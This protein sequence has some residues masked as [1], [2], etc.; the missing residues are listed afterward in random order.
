MPDWTIEDQLAFMAGQGISR[1]IFSFST[2]GPNILPGNRAVTIALARALNEVAAAY[3][4]AYPGKFNFYVQVPLPYTQDAII[5][6]KYAMTLPGAVGVWLQSNAEG[7]YLGDPLFKN[8]FQT[9]NSWPGRQIVYVH[10]SIPY[11][12]VGNQLVEANP[13]PYLTGKIE[14]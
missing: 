12:K 14:F 6:M 7:I 8:F 5:E 10:P 9:I 3:C 2:P 11:L 4:R 1:A 13:T